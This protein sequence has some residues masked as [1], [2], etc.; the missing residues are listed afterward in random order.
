M[1]A[2]TLATKM[3]LLPP[4]DPESKGM[5]E[6]RNGFF[7]TSFMPGRHF[8]S[9]ADF[10]D[11]FTD[12][13]TPANARV[14]RTIK[15]RPIE[16]MEADKA[17]MLPLPPAVLHLGWRN[18][19]R[20]GRDYYVRIDTNDYSVDPRAIGSRIDVVADLDA[21]RVRHGG[22]LVADHPRRWARG[23]TVTDPAHVK[24]AARLAPRLPTPDHSTRGCGPGPRP[25]R[26]RQSVR[27]RHP[28]D[29]DPAG[30]ATMTA[31][32][33]STAAADTLKQITHLAAALKAPRITEA[34]A[35]LAD[36]ARD[37]GWTHE[38][39]LAA[40]L[41]REVAAR[42]ASGARL[43]IRAAA[44]PAIKTIDDFDF[45]HQP[46]ARTPIHALASGAY[47]SEHRNVVLLGPPGTGKTHVATALGVAACRQGHRVLFATATDWI[48]RLAEAHDRTAWP[49]NSPGCAATAL[50]IVDEVG[51][52]PFEQDAAN[53]FFQLVSSRY[54][55]AS[56]I[57]TSNLPF[58][59][60][61]AVF[62]D[63]VVAAAMIDRI[64]HHADVIALKGASYRLRDRG[65][66]T[67]PSIKAEQQ[68]LD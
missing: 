22:R 42:N 4:K 53:L 50:I 20:L 16:L 52:L 34:A 7:E 32:P 12:W 9:P 24:A 45:D 28:A 41:D 63:Q 66:D 26:L 31:K 27:P 6:R 35:R 57:L 25:G 40:V 19:V 33:T 36:H 56:L 60:W 43:R 15:A 2:G 38:D 14:V 65:V 37:A 18:H 8:E 54:E 23:M 21:V 30:R 46:A 55:H 51:Y 58:S 68:S 64:V 29:A 13:L 49:P 48:T 39:Y 47:L 17:A 67:L 61:A 59:G 11:Q 44:M 1:F 10:N 62:G 5:V 3:V